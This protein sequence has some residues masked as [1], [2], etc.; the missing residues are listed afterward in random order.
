MADLDACRTALEG[1]SD[2]LLETGRPLP[3]RTVSCTVT[4]LGVT[5]HGQLG[6][7]GLGEIT[8]DEFPPAK[9]RLSLTS[10]DLVALVDGALHAG[11][12]FASGRLGVKASFGDLMLLRSLG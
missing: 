3:D 5:F 10:D 1:L 12:A 2:R 4:D 7:A 9:I 11:S 6:P 8:T